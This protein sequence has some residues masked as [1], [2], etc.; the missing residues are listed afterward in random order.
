MR[1]RIEAFCLDVVMV[2]FTV[3]IVAF[4]FLAVRLAING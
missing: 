1:N 2:A 3:A 4:A